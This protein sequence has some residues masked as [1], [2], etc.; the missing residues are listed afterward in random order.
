LWNVGFALREERMRGTLESNWLS[1]SWRFSLLLGNSAVQMVAM[2]IFIGVSL[3]E[4]SI[5]YGVRFNGDPILVTLMFLVSIPSIYGLG[6]AF[7]S[8]VIIAREANAFVF[9]VRGLVM[10]FCG[11]T[12][13]IAVL[14][15]WMQNVAMFLPQT[16]IIYGFR[17]AMLNA[18]DFQTLLP[19]Y[20]ILLMFGAFWLAVGFALFRRMERRAR[21]TGALGQY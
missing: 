15:G 20:G 13:P 1:P 19:V 21:Q 10:I 2:L 4:F 16:Y 7:A 11:I 14:P 12:Y 3:I 6:F 18:A 8:V 9:L 5:L 17:Q